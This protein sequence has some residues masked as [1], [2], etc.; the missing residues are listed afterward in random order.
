MCTSNSQPPGLGFCDE[1]RVVVVFRIGGV[2]GDDELAAVVAA[3]GDLRRVGL[4]RD[5]ARLAQNF[6][7]KGGAQAVAGDG[8][9]DVHARVA[10]PTE[11]LDHAADGIGGRVL[12]AFQIDDDELSR[13][14][15]GVAG[16]V[17]AAF[18]RLVVRFRP[19]EFVFLPENADDAPGAAGNHLDDLAA[20]FLIVGSRAALAGFGGRAGGLDADAVAVESGEGLAARDEDAGVDCEIDAD[21]FVLQIA[22]DRVEKR[23]AVGHELD[24][25][26]ER[27]FRGG[28]THAAFS[29]LNGCF[30][31]LRRYWQG[32]EF[33]GAA[34]DEFPGGEVAK[35]S[36]EFAV[37]VG[38]D[39]ERFGDL[40]F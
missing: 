21:R 5:G 22:D 24:R 4:L 17:D 30:L 19:C 14:R 32:I 40:A 36:G 8:R 3:A 15:G 16:D 27:S 39:I 7:G 38:G 11:H 12:P 37:A 20:H 34:Y 13:L 6:L 23:V 28:L 31:F 9:E 29:F 10:G 26:E 35:H 25:A 2:D 1:D 33:L 18:E